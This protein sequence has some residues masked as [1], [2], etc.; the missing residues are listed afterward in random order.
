MF[1]K[2]SLFAFVSCLALAAAETSTVQYPT[3]AEIEAS[4]ESVLPY[5][6]VSNVRGLAFD[7]FVNIWI[8]NTDFDTT[9]ADKNFEALAKEGIML[10]NYFG[11]SHPSEPNYCASAAGDD[12]GMDNDDWHQIPANVSTI[13]DLFDTKGVAWG[14]YQEAMPYAGK[15]NKLFRFT[16]FRYPESGPNDYVRKHNPLILFD[17]VTNDAVRPRQIKNFTSFYEDLEHHRLP[18]HMFITPNMTN[19]AHDTNITVAGDFLARF[20]PPLLQNEYFTKDT[21]VLVTFDETATYKQENR[22][23]SFLLGGAVPEHLKGT[24]DDTFYTHYSVIASLS[25]NWGLPSLGRWDCGANLLNLVAEKTG[26]VNWEVDL[27]TIAE[28][29]YLNQTSPARCL[30]FSSEW[31]IPTVHERCSAGHGI[32]DIVKKTYHGLKPTYNYLSPIPY[33]A[34]AGINTGVEYT[35]T[36]KN[37]KKERGIT[38]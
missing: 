38:N 20:L 2:K 25:A 5:S 17:S 22:V 33:S 26:Y 8:E 37:G 21:L 23:Y 7:R 1:T 31:P 32:L 27:K 16:G 4:R 29:D 14:E 11:V 13:A 35:R 10:T 6:P 12:F 24:Q 9:A 3:A 19:D 30:M 34:A 28:N 18:Q 15:Q 36:R